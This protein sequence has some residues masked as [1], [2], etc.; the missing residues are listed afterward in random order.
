MMILA[1]A[2][3]PVG[4]GIELLII[5]GLSCYW[6]RISPL[7]LVSMDGDAFWI[8]LVGV[9]TIILS[10]VPRRKCRLAGISVGRTDR[11]L[12]V[13][14][15][16]RRMTRFGS[17]TAL[18]ATLWL[19]MNLP[20]PQLISFC[21]KRAHIPRLLT[22][23]KIPLTWRFLYSSDEA[24]AIRR[25][26]TLQVFGYCSLPNGYRSFGN[27]GWTPVYA[28]VNALSAND[29]HAGYQTVSGDFHL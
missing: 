26:Q 7:A 22:E 5:A 11:G 28:G 4:Q 12:P 3:L 8:S 29:Y 24:V 20:F 25:A 6:L 19:V 16:S 17:S 2:L 18:S 23:S 9:I 14:A 1:F 21:F 27:A 10:I 15:W 13:R